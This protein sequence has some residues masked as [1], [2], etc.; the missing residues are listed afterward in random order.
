MKSILKL[1]FP[2]KF[3][4]EKIQSFKAE[5]NERAA[6]IKNIKTKRTAVICACAAIGVLMIICY[7][8]LGKQLLL[9]INDKDAFKL[10]LE[11]FGIWGRIIF[12]LLR[13]VQTVIKIIPAEPLEIGA[14]YVFG[15]WGGLLYCSIGSLA[16]SFIILILT[17]KF[18]IKIT[19]LFVSKKKI[20]SL[21]F[22]QN[23]KHLNISLFI[24]YLIPS[25]PKDLITYFIGLT[26]ENIPLFL[27]I[28]AVGRIPSIITSTW[29]GSTLKSGNYSAAIIIFAATAVL[30]LGGAYIY[31]RISGRKE[32]EKGKDLKEEK[33]A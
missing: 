22:L 8:T 3:I 32:N 11:N 9:F 2:K 12:I 29:C 1:K 27:L 28:T 5:L 10:W 14:G 7:F 23:K 30:G 25:T 18:G 6:E 16:G 4:T 33:I 26:D 21:A 17:R 13:T 24:I 20:E 15:T 31:N 19:E